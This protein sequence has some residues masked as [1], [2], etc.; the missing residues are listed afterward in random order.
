MRTGRFR[1]RKTTVHVLGDTSKQEQ[2]LSKR[3]LIRDIVE[4][5]HRPRTLW[6]VQPRSFDS[7]LEGKLRI[8]F[9]EHLIGVG[10]RVQRREGQL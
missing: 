1:R 8:K 6:A 5:S 2:V 10:D 9:E 7:V 4:K 3:P